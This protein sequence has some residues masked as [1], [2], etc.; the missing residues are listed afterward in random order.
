MY[1][2]L[3]FAYVGSSK[4]DHTRSN[5]SIE[6]FSSDDSELKPGESDPSEIG[7]PRRLIS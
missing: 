1:V 4:L 5:D 2:V 6:H 3:L 7:V